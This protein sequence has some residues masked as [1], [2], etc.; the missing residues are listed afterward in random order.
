MILSNLVKL[1][2]TL[3]DVFVGICD[4]CILLLFDK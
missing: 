2:E 4:M 1:N 3:N